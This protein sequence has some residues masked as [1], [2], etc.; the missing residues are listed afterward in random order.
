[1]SAAKLQRHFAGT[2]DLCSHRL[3]AWIT[4]FATKRL[5]EMRKVT[6]AGILLGGYGWV[7]NLKPAA[8][9]ALEVPPIGEQGV[10]L[11]P[12]NNP[13]YTHTPSLAQ[14]ATVAVLR[15]GHLTHSDPATKDLLAIDLSSERV[16]LAEWLLDG[17]RQGQ[18]LGALLG[19]RF[20][21]HLQ[22]AKLGQFIPL[23]REVAP[24][25]AK[26]LS[27][28]T[29]QSVNE[30]VE[31]IAANN[32]VDG[33]VLHNK[34]KNLPK[35][36]PMG[37][38]QIL[39]SQLAKDKAPDFAT[40]Q[41]ARPALQAELDLLAEA[42]DA[43][44]DAFIAESVYHAVQGNPLRTAST[45]DAVASGEA[46]PPELEVVLTPRT[47]VAQTH[48][49]VAL[50]GGSPA[51]GQEWVSP[52]VSQRANAEPYLNAWVAKL[53]GNPARVRCVIERIDPA[54]AEMLES[55]ELR[56]DELHLSP[57][58][59]IYS[60]GSN[61]GAQTS[62]IQQRILYSAIRRPDGFAA[63]AV[64]RINP[65]RAPGWATSD[66]SYG[67]YT[68]LLR[69]ARQLITGARGIDASELDLPEQ[70]HPSGVD[71][72]ELQTRANN[73]AQALHQTQ[74]DLQGLLDKGP[75]VNLE[76]LREVL[77]HSA[78]FG[79]AGA[80]PFSVVGSS[81]ADRDALL[82]QGGSIA[83]ELA[84]RLD[85]LTTL[86]ANVNASSGTVDDKRDQQLARLRSIFGNS[87]VVLP[88]FSVANATDLERALAD[89]AKVQDNDALTVITWFQRASRVRE[90]VARFDASIRY[91][92]AL[93]TGE[94]LNLRIAQ[95]PY[96]EG[97]RWVGLPLKPGQGI[98]PSRF[99]LLVQ[100]APTIDVKQ[101]MTGLLIDE[102]VEA[103]PNAT[104]T[105]GMVFQYDQPDAA[106]P[107][108]ILLAVPA[109]LDQP[110][111]L[112]SLQQVLLETLDLARIRAVDPN[113]LE[114]G[115]T[116]VGSGGVFQLSIGH[117][118]PA[119]YF[120]VNSAGDTVSTDFLKL[121]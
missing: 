67:E 98:S 23:F 51:V 110:W 80:V 66:L 73:A 119:L 34:W 121:K 18:P 16:R 86:E 79:V 74:S 31:S 83:K 62:E 107:Q 20:E 33:L 50:F 6:P 102:W 93:E 32:V 109:D 22:D 112:W 19:Y 108:C 111:N 5:A 1:L 68:E 120:A 49:L 46:P 40:L 11:R 21:R 104:E 88:Q 13:G 90:G 72:A 2:L 96:R 81:P 77:L 101:P 28:T 91:A 38:L 97:D 52:A 103:V 4:S 99:S 26:K 53:L 43:L 113:V 24:L 44:S 82:L 54:T 64:L 48:R 89:S 58:D 30:S 56:L 10:F 61:R 35:N 105:T 63:D 27:Q 69:A 57:L 100:S 37:P 78:Q 70:N 87:F 42:V 85:R 75:A 114:E 47:G 94:Q 95:L 39:F 76:V 106:P 29:N 65:G 118:L 41:Q 117:Y 7:M 59:F 9:P 60:A 17:V 14:A 12:A 15:S 115:T 55:K 25:V 45:L 3:D 71:I 92:E 116:A 36:A 84:Q 8:P